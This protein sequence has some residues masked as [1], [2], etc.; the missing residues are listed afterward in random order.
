MRE[1]S[2]QGRKKSRNNCQIVKKKHSGKANFVDKKKIFDRTLAEFEEKIKQ[3]ALLAL[4]DDVGRGDITTNAIMRDTGARTRAFI[5]AKEE[6]VFCGVLEARAVLNGLKLFWRKKEGAR[7]KRGE[8]VL[9][10]EGDVREI[11]RRC[12]IALNYLQS[13]SGIATKTSRLV[14][15]FGSR[16]CSLRKT[17]PCLQFSEKRA[18]QVGGGFTHRLNLADG[19]LIK[20]SHIAAVAMELF[21]KQKKY[22][23]KQKIAAIREAIMRCVEY[24]R[25][26]VSFPIE[27]EVES[28]AQALAAVEAKK[29]T[30]APD[31]ILLDNQTPKQIQKIVRAVRRIDNTILIEASGGINEKNIPAFLR[32]GVDVVSMSELTLHAKP[33]DF[34]LVVEGYK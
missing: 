4:D 11:L 24:R 29:K 3:R 33:L 23:E 12:R 26:R 31:A 17:H 30:G 27:V 18:V 22:A 6:G 1:E 2:V 8:V 15:K 7:V 20:D 34:N 9:V 28:L 13:L 21:G 5:R 14:E 32:A 16:I 10:V 19:F 25:S